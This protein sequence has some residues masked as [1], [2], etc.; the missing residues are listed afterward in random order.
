MI[1]KLSL[2]KYC[3]SNFCS[4]NKVVK[5]VT[6]PIKCVWSGSVALIISGGSDR[7]KDESC[8]LYTKGAKHIN[9]I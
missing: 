6:D 2:S 7:K 4:R 8:G 3:V 1:G 9:H 5:L